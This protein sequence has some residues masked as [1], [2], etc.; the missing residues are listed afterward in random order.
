MERNRFIWISVPWLANPLRERAQIVYKFRRNP[1]SAHG[2]FE[3]RN[4]ILKSSILLLLLVLHY[5]H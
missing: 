1:F 4:K 5:Y 3:K 2:N